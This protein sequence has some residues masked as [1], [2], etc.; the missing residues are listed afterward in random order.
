[1]TVLD[2]F[3]VSDGYI[4]GGEGG[5]CCRR[6]AGSCLSTSFFNLRIMMVLVSSLFSSPWLIEPATRAWPFQANS[7]LWQR[8]N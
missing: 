2:M 4:G 7:E 5:A 6:L 3:G 8:V 1:M